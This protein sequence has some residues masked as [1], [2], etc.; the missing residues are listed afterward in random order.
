AECEETAFGDRARDIAA[1]LAAHFEQAGAHQR[2]VRYLMNAAD[3]AT[4]RSANTEAAGYLWR[5][6]DLCEL[7]PGAERVAGRL[8]LLE[9]LAQVRRAMGDTKATV[10]GFETFAGYARE[11]GRPDEEARALLELSGALS[12]IDRDRSLA[13]IEQALALTPSLSGAAL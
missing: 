8:G 1:D 2:A 4:R 3:T 6:L 11:Q 5:A 12:W 13:A 7:L 9:Q 10:E